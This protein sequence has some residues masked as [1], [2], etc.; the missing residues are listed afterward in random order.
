MGTSEAWTIPLLIRF[1]T[2]AAGVS[3]HSRLLLGPFTGAT[4]PGDFNVAGLEGGG[5]VGG[6]SFSF[7]N[8]FLSSS[9]SLSVKAP[10]A[11]GG[12]D[13]LRGFGVDIATPYGSKSSVDD[14][15]L[16]ASPELPDLS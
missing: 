6:V 9:F 14:G 1:W 3:R 10:S 8:F 13:G 7:S 16:E 5:E 12:A 2:S 11:L 4:G 15:K